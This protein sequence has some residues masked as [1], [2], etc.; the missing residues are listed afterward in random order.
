VPH[1][2]NACGPPDDVDDVVRSHPWRFDQGEYAV[3]AVQ[4]VRSGGRS[5][6]DAVADALSS[7][8]TTARA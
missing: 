8:C 5:E 2:A 7:V 4:M 3:H 6:G 1:A